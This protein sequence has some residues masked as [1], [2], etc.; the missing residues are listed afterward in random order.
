M[1]TSDL[2]S[3]N[4]PAG[5]LEA[6]SRLGR[7]TR[8][9]EQ[10]KLEQSRASL[11]RGGA[12][13]SDYEIQKFHRFVTEE[14]ATFEEYVF[15]DR[16]G[17]ACKTPRKFDGVRRD[18]S[19]AG[20]FRVQFTLPGQ[21]DDPKTIELVQSRG[22]DSPAFGAVRVKLP[23]DATVVSVEGRLIVKSI[24]KNSNGEKSSM[25]E[26]DIIRAVSFPEVEHSD[27]DKKWHHTDTEEGMVVL[28]GKKSAS[29]YN[30]V[31]RE[32]IRLSGD[33]AE[34]VL[35]LERP[36]D[37][38]T[39]DDDQ[40]FMWAFPGYKQ[41][42]FHRFILEDDSTFEEYVFN[43]MGGYRCKTPDKFVGSRKAGSVAGS[44]RVQFTLPE[45]DEEPKTVELLQSNP[46]DTPSF[47]SVK[48]KLPIQATVLSVDGRLVV[49]KVKEDSNAEDSGI[50]E[51]DIIRA[52]SLPSTDIS[53]WTKSGR[54]FDRLESLIADAEQGMVSCDGKKSD[55]LY[56]AAIRENL[57][58]SGDESEV[59][60]LIERPGEPK[61]ENVEQKETAAASNVRELPP[62]ISQVYPD[63]SAET[64]DEAR[65]TTS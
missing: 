11:F 7:H 47:G 16:T 25:K 24:P 15:N 33:N 21:D 2:Q 64:H 56:D 13:S 14:D 57:R 49:N 45:K 19:I 39:S 43:D 4:S 40:G 42:K 6:K 31:I 5:A 8:V 32:N 54:A 55:S 59:V 29:I 52:L 37:T 35:V 62:S 27:R 23:I 38:A 26:G 20:S 9:K 36:S 61:D 60:L 44:F 53:W 3:R 17:F 10:S 48:V 30:A 50:A 18:G 34:V 58:V 46:D 51:G 12:V 63:R 1:V 22:N 65:A 28:G 41:D